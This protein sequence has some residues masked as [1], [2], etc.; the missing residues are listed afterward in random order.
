MEQIYGKIKKGD[1]VLIDNIPILI[2]SRTNQISKLSEWYGS[3]VSPTFIDIMPAGSFQLFLD[4]GRSGNIIITNM[5]MN[6]STKQ[7]FYFTG[8]GPLSYKN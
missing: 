3:F 8:N 4:D 1:T 2:S 7:V 6:N 5:K